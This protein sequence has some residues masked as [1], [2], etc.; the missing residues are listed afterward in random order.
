MQE[1]T[2]STLSWIKLTRIQR[3]SLPSS[4]NVERGCGAGSDVIR[5][6][7]RSQRQPRSVRG[8]EPPTS[9][10][11]VFPLWKKSSDGKPNRSYRSNAKS[12]EQSNP[13]DREGC[14][15]FPYSSDSPRPKVLS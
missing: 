8:I 4:N 11:E 5:S 10:E 1:K 7:G 6:R 12:N 2:S 13:P 15:S 14:R 9:T 3:V